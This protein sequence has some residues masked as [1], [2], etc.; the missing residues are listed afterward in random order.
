MKKKWLYC[1]LTLIMSVTALF[2]GCFGIGGTG[3]GNGKKTL[4]TPKN[5]AYNEET[6]TLSWESVENATGYTLDYNGKETALGGE[7]TEY[8]VILSAVENTFKLK[9]TGDKEK[10]EDS[11][12]AEVTYT[13]T[14]GNEE[15]GDTDSGND[16][17]ASELSLYDK[18]NIELS[19]AAAEE[20]Y[21]L[22]RVI[23]IS[24]ADIEEMYKF[25]HIRIETIGKKNNIDYNIMYGYR[26]DEAS[27][28]TELLNS[29]NAEHCQGSA[30]NPLVSYN[31]A[32]KFVASEKYDGKMQALYEQGYTISVLDS[33]V[34]EGKTVAKKFRYEIV[35]TYKA[36]NAYGD[37][38]YFTSVNQI[39][40]NEVSSNPIRNYETTFLS[41]SLITVTEKQFVLH[42]EGATLEYMAKLIEQQERA[43]AEKESA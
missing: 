11:A 9:A 32:E 10:Y 33:C 30:E 21:T 3:G 6:Y 8:T 41:P 7:I 1:L 38:K 23:G 17:G 20:G 12:W 14:G 34:R 35:G 25:D 36:E 28:F 2:T 37:V 27:D 26:I 43:L 16:N 13:L 15:N 40:V 31:S 39:D 22:E 19:R 29:I 5:F 42:E 4:Q 24:Y 18:I